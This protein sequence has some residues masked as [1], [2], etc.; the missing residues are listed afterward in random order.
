MSNTKSN[1]PLKSTGARTTDLVATI[2]RNRATGIPT[3]VFGPPGVGKSEQVHQAAAGETVIDVR[4][5]ML[6]PVD[7]RGLPTVTKGKNGSEVEWA[8]PEFIPAEGRGIIVFDELNTAPIAVQNAALQII[9]DRK[10]GPHK[11]GRVVHRRLR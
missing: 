1:N 11:R 7:L 6:D 4:L 9:L 10:C 2:K 3:F 5:S 8:R